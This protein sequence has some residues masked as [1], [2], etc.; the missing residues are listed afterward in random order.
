MGALLKTHK[1]SEMRGFM[2]WFDRFACN[3]IVTTY[4]DMVVRYPFCPTESSA[5]APVPGGF[6]SG[7]TE[8]NS[9]VGLL[10]WW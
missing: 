4:I 10:D 1:S 9:E 6:R 3:S 7:K 5:L 2:D 8:S